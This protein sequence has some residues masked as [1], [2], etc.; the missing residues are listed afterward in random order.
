[1]A[2]TQFGI[3]YGLISDK[4]NKQLKDQNVNFDEEKI[5][6]FQKMIDTMHLLRFN[7]FIPDSQ[8]DKMIKKLHT[9]ITKH[10]AEHNKQK[11]VK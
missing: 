2:T 6:R 9:K 11:V 3:S 1:M 5:E 8:F 7:N 4:L 10:I